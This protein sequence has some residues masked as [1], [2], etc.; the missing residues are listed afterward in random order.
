MTTGA[1][2]TTEEDIREI[3]AEEAAPA[4]TAAND[5]LTQANTA[6]AAAGAAVAQAQA[7]VTA[8][9]A[10]VAKSGDVMSGN[11]RIRGSTLFLE[12]GSTLRT[13]AGTLANPAIQLGD[14]NTGFWLRSNNIMGVTAGGEDVMTIDGLGS[15]FVNMTFGNSHIKLQ[16][17][18]LGCIFETVNDTGADWCNEQVG[19]LGSAYAYFRKSNGTVNARAALLSGEKIGGLGF[20]A[21]HGIDGDVAIGAEI[22]VY[23]KGDQASSNHG[24][25]MDFRVAAQGAAEQHVAMRL[26]H[27]GSLRLLDYNGSGEVALLCD[28]N[29]KIKR[30]SAA[31]AFGQHFQHNEGGDESTGTDSIVALA[32]T[33]E[34]LSAGTYRIMCHYKWAYNSTG[35]DFYASLLIDGTK[36]GESHRQEPKDSASGGF[37]GTDQRHTAS[38]LV[39]QDFATGDTPLIQL[40]FRGTGG[41]T[42]T[43]RNPLIEIWRV[44]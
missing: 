7:A 25:R 1:A 29:G 11:L 43:V 21:H 4:S 9:E 8:A 24:A 26:D 33:S 20:S 15:P 22:A 38:F 19:S 39:Y 14:S 41:S 2:A 35:S 6:L 23:T 34:P 37:G 32:L 5:A 40:W 10:R 13:D 44:A 31:S 18:G 16:E 12:Q 30:G 3:A 36:I 28:Q 27:N 17:G 42:A